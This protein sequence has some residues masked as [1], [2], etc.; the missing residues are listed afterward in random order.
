MLSPRIDG[1]RR[2]FWLLQAGGWGIFFAAMFL[3]GVGQ[4]PLGHAFLRKSALTLAG[5]GLT[6]LL[7]LAYRALRTRGTL[8]VLVAAIAVTLSCL[9]AGVWMAIQN[10]VIAALNGPHNPGTNVF[11]TFPDFTNTIYY[12]FVLIAWSALYFG[13]PLLLSEKRD[14]DRLESVEALATQ[15]QLRALR[16]QLN[17]HFLFNSLNAVSTLIAEGRN[18]EANRMLGKVSDFLRM[19]LESHEAR[20]I[21]VA[22][23][24]DFVRRYLDI[25]RSRFGDRL[26]IRIDVGDDA[27]QAL[28]PPMI[29]QPLVENAVR[30][31]VVPR[32]A[33]GA[34]TIS[35]SRQESWLMLRVDDDGPGVDEVHGGMGIGLRNVRERLAHMYDERADLRLERND[36]GG[37]AVAIRLPFREVAT[38]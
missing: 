32:E 18:R 12:A 25:E 28:V 7:R 17:P 4:W 27:D 24:M 8:L 9:G 23:E 38:P 31:A 6:L 30:N 14:R 5:L 10:L 16:L 2:R 1:D 3:A 29:L 33:G 15:A 35:A 26:Q 19:T 11:A 36:G 20:E 21:S 13:L 34:V 22:A 37:V